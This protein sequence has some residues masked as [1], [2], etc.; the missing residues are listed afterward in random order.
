MS[1]PTLVGVTTGEILTQEGDEELKILPSASP[2]FGEVMTNDTS[3]SG[4][5]S[6]D[7]RDCWAAAAHQLDQQVEETDAS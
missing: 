2:Q 1:C 6:S 3:K 7:P 4:D 5:G